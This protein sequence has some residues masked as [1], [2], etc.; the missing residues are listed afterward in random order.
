MTPSEQPQGYGDPLFGHRT[1]KVVDVAA[2]PPP[3][4][5]GRCEGPHYRRAI[6]DALAEHEIPH[7]YARQRERRWQRW[8][9]TAQD[10]DRRREQRAAAVTARSLQLQQAEHVDTRALGFDHCK[11]IYREVQ[12]ALTLEDVQGCGYHRAIDWRDVAAIASELVETF[13]PALDHFHIVDAREHLD[14]R[15]ANALSSP[16]YD[17]IWWSPGDTGVSNG[18]HRT[19]AL[20]VGGAVRVPV[21][22]GEI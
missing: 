6:A 20:R 1:F 4:N 3:H 18:Q 13:G 21:A 14:K 9:P 2:I 19:C 15:T 11:A 17:P 7:V 8:L 5:P 12:Y 10:L 16:F 22:P